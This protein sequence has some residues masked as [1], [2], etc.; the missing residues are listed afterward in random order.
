MGGWSDFKK[1]VGK[2]YDSAKN[3]VGK[4]H[5]ALGWVKNVAGKIQQIPVVGEAAEAALVGTPQGR[6]LLTTFEALDEGTELA[7]DA[8]DIIDGK[9]IPGK[10]P[11][12]NKKRTPVPN[13][14]MIYRKMNPSLMPVKNNRFSQGTVGDA[15]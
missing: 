7:Q 5:N 10:D 11:A 2:V 9:T 15:I 4:V 13:K 14:N 8:F 6:R 12:L 1:F 3:T